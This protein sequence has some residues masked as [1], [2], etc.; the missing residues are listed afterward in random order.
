MEIFTL[1]AEALAIISI[2]GHVVVYFIH[3]TEERTLL[4]YLHGIRPL[5]MSA[6]AGEAVGPTAWNDAVEQ[7][8]DMM[9]RLQPP[10][11]KKK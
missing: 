5:L 11:K 7:V 3:R 2:I 9:Q 8:N 1:F 4:G 6:A 10:A